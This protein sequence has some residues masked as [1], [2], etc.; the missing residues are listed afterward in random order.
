MYCIFT[1]AVL[2]S[3]ETDKLCYGKYIFWLQGPAKGVILQPLIILSDLNCASKK[4]T[5][6][7]TCIFLI[8]EFEQQ[9][10]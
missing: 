7:L 5:T 3:N 4:K 10:Y 6:N 9:K 2:I 8:S 1:V